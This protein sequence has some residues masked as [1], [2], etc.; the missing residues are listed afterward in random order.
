MQE[1]VDFCPV[2][3]SVADQGGLPGDMQW[4]CS[5]NCSLY[6][7]PA[8]VCQPMPRAVRGNG[9]GDGECRSQAD[10]LPGNT[11]KTPLIHRESRGFEKWW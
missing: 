10:E 3:I 8:M 7:A 9:S 5:R 1:A 6:S 2:V 4:N 11:E